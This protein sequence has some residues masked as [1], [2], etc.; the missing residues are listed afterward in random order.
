MGDELPIVVMIFHCHIFE[1]DLFVCLSRFCN[2]YIVDVFDI[3]TSGG[4]SANKANFSKNTYSVIP[5]SYTH[6]TLPTKRIV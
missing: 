4:K 6:L 2:I 5:V 1:T 3:K